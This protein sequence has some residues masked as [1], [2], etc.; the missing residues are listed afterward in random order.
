MI[1]HD[2]D[3][4]NASQGNERKFN[5]K[6]HNKKKKQKNLAGY[7]YYIAIQYNEEQSSRR[8]EIQCLV[9]VAMAVAWNEFKKMVENWVE[10]GMNFI[11][12]RKAAEFFFKYCV[13]EFR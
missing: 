2:P 13:R 7:C 8:K 9:A 4:E 5:K 6:K 10:G 12:P 1:Y 11:W 3:L